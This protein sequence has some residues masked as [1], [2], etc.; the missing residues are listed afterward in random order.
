MR[1]VI[2]DTETTG[3]SP[4]KDKIIEISLIE[5]DEKNNLTGNFFHS[6]INPQKSIPRSASLVHGI[7][8]NTIKDSPTFHELKEDILNFIK[9]KELISY[10]TSFNIKILNYELGFRVS[11]KTID[12]LKLAKEIYPEGKFN[13]NNMMQRMKIKKEKIFNNQLFSDCYN[14]YLIYKKLCEKTCKDSN[15]L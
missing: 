11:N 4:Q 8:Y 6:F 3:L 2:I 10:Y 12:V 5:I 13:L 9:D 1:K 15:I 14:T 7:R